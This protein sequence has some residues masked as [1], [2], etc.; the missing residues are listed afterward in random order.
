MFWLWVMV[1]VSLCKGKK[2]RTGLCVSVCVLATV[3]NPI[4]QQG[5]VTGSAAQ[6]QLS[7]PV[8]QKKNPALQFRKPRMN[9]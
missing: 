4:L 3:V 5:S 7:N 6:T 9:L 8:K 1:T 2:K